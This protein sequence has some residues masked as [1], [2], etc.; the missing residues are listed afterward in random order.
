MH[1]YMLCHKQ[2]Y[3]NKYDAATRTA[4][5]LT[6]YEEFLPVLEIYLLLGN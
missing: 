5:V 1:Y 4:L 2:L 3:E 6:D